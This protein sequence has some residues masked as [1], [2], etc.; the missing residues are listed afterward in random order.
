MP[1]WV[2]DP[3]LVQRNLKVSEGS[4]GPMNTETK[5]EKEREKENSMMSKDILAGLVRLFNY[6]NIPFTHLDQTENGL[7]FAKAGVFR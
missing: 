5:R 1:R 3:A 6:E 7:K 4:D 2:E